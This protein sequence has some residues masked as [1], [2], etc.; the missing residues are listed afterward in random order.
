MSDDLTKEIKVILTL[1][2]K[3]S[4]N[5]SV[6]LTD[7]QIK[8]LG[9]SSQLSAAQID[10]AFKQIQKSSTEALKSWKDFHNMADMQGSS[11]RWAEYKRSVVEA[12][13]ALNKVGGSADALKEKVGGIRGVFN[14][15]FGEDLGGKILNMVTSLGLVAGAAELIRKGF[16][17]L[18]GSLDAFNERQTAIMGVESTIKSMG[19]ETSITTNQIFQMAEQMER[20]NK[21][22]FE[23]NQI[24][25]VAGFL[26]SFDKITTDIL[27]KATQM[28]IDLAA[29]MHLDLKSAAIAFG[30]ALDNPAEGLMRLG[31][32]GIKFSSD[33]REAIK[34]MVD[35]GNEAGAQ[36]LIFDTLQ[37]KVGG[38]AANTVT[39][40]QEMKNRLGEYFQSIE[41]SVGGFIANAINPILGALTKMI[42]EDA[43]QQWM[44]LSKAV[45]NTNDN[46]L[47]LIGTYSTLIAKGNLNKI[48]QEELKTAIQKIGEAF[49]E[50][51]T[52]WDKY[53]NAISIST[54]KLLELIK[55]QEE[56]RKGMAQT[57]V[58]QLDIE[59]GE[60][61]R[62]LYASQELMKKGYQTFGESD[63]PIKIQP[64]EYKTMQD[65]NLAYG[66]RML[67]IEKE[68]RTLLGE[69]EPITAPVKGTPKGDSDK[70]KKEKVSQAIEDLKFIDAD[71]YKYKI[72][73]INDEAEARLKDGQDAAKVAMAK[74][75]KLRALAKEYLDFVD[76]EFRPYGFTGDAKIGMKT[77]DQLV[78]EVPGTLPIKDP[79]SIS[80]VKE[81]TLALQAQLTLTESLKEGF[82]SAGN[83]LAGSMGSAVH[84]FGQANSLLEQFINNLASA[85]VK[86]LALKAA[87]WLISLIP[88]LAHEGGTFEGTSSGVKKM[89]IGGSFIVPP[90]FNNDSFPLMVESGEG[91]TVT[92]RNRMSNIMNNIMTMPHGITSQG[93]QAQTITIKMDPVEFKQSG[94][95]LRAIGKL[96]DNY[97]KTSR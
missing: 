87:N 61:Q 59:N 14:S 13:G 5:T 55:A 77:T 84:L 34:A 12:S 11:A 19:K 18:S 54:D 69:N 32:A 89:G 7:E 92:P 2:G 36:T 66:K 85:I 41:R 8:S 1:E 27:P 53:G 78:K 79:G 56:A 81:T 24:M 44:D 31:R 40:F 88:F 3:D 80:I 49:P 22:R 6:K 28:V 71:Y 20:A 82:D 95:A 9:V 43:Y 4:V 91:V 67:E 30:I 74:Y 52:S 83:A 15:V 51:I 50:A 45:K 76:K 10:K 86:T 26:L 96:T 90:G 37:K 64:E 57:S 47:P 93:S 42:P 63:T 46:I 60:L 72:G 39:T 94:M 75:D 38:Y 21:F 97:V 68:R 25:D 17:F 16:Q 65:N 23:A 62:K 29:K 73:L 58:K 48:Q 35:A 33:E 70:A